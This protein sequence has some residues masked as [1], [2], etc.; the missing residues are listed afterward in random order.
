MQDSKW[1]LPDGD[2]QNVSY[3]ATTQ[4]PISSQDG[5]AA[6]S[7]DI[8]ALD[9]NIMFGRQHDELMERLDTWIMI[10]ENRLTQAVTASLMTS[11]VVTG[12]SQVQ[13]FMR[14]S[15]P[16]SRYHQE[17]MVTPTAQFDVLF[18][19]H[20]E[21]GV[22]WTHEHTH[23]Y[24]ENEMSPRDD[25]TLEEAHKTTSK[26]SAQ[27]SCMFKEQSIGAVKSDFA[28][29]RA[30][31][32]VV[33]SHTFSAISALAIVSS[34]FLLGVEVEYAARNRTQ[35]M[36]AGFQAL[37]YVFTVVFFIE[38][39]CR[40]I[41][42][43]YLFF[44]QKQIGWNALDVVLVFTSCL[45]AVMEI[46]I[47]IGDGDINQTSGLMGNFRI[48]RLLRVFRMTR[49]IRLVRFVQAVM[50]VR[51][52]RVLLHSIQT[53]LRTLV[54]TLFLLLFITYFFGVLFT[55]AAVEHMNFLYAQ[56]KDDEI[57]PALLKWWGSLPESMFTL[58]KS[59]TGGVD[60]D[61]CVRALEGVHIMWVCL[62]VFFISITFFAVL[63]VVTGVFCNS[64]IEGAKY[65]RDLL[66]HDLVENKNTYVDKIRDVFVSIYEK[67]DEDK[68]GAITL[69]EFEEHIHDD[70][71]QAYFALL[72]L[73]TTDAFALFK[74][75]DQDGSNNL[76]PDEF[77]D[78]CLK[79]KGSARSIDLAKLS[80]EHQWLS[81][82]LM[83]FM[84]QTERKVNEIS[85]SVKRRPMGAGSLKMNRGVSEQDHLRQ[86]S[87]FSHS[88]VLRKN[89]VDY[90]KP[91]AKEELMAQPT[92]L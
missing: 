90:E 92:T 82:K 56:G 16:L 14:Q 42:D 26:V 72:E 12:L 39:S 17:D 1:A 36:P 38:L 77:I 32:Q 83:T 58:F 49:L 35:S 47:A 27:L 43:G 29:R 65:D 19:E 24:E 78:G 70:R 79:L 23:T 69:E 37:Q 66:M 89:V 46:M 7:S 8:T 76:D 74:L 64:A 3:V 62:Y 21:D 18:A 81:K 40:A 11:P 9:A 52:L 84:A 15:T 4:K 85:S 75:L 80:Y 68:S 5:A 44:D 22:N 53:T 73:D 87:Q 31:Q 59:I 54:W 86:T 30:V 45:E 20:P 10:Q 71:V 63:N 55:H 33:K 48:V 88:Q 2:Y 34:C 25:A 57:D 13:S 60:W 28:W 61:N 6:F 41:A 50:F 51:A 67:I 91:S